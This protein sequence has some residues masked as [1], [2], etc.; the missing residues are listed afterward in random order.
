[1]TSE[2]TGQEGQSRIAPAAAARMRREI[3]DAGGREVFFAGSLNAQGL[4]EDV[5]VCAR[6]NED[7]VLALFDKLVLR[8]VVIHN[9]PTGDLG[10][11]EADMDVAAV[12][13]HN[14]HGVF[15]VDNAISRVYVVVEPFLE[16][17]TH[18][19]DPDEMARAFRPDG[20]MA[21]VLPQY[22]VRPQQRAMLESVARAFN[23]DGI[24]V[25][26]APTGVGKTFAYLIPAVQ[27]A[28]E[29][30][31]RVV[32][33]TRTINLQEQI[34]LKDIPQLKRCLGL[35]FKAVLVKGR[36]NYLCQR[37][38]AR[39]FSEM[40]LFEDDETQANLKSLDEW[41]KKTEDGSRSDLPF[42][43]TRDL[44]EKV[45]S[46]GDTCVGSRCPSAKTCFVT[47][48]RRE[49]ARADLIV[50]NHHMLFS[51]I[52]VKKDMGDFS[53][54]AVL[55]A[56]KRVLFDEAHSIEDS[57]T[58]YFGVQATRIGAMV[59]LGRFQ[60]KER[61]HERGLLPVVKMRLVKESN[62]VSSVECDQILDLIDNELLPSLAAVREAL[63][64]AFG[65]LR[66]LTAEKCGQI[67]R[68]IKW[69]LTERELMDPALRETHEVYVMP[70]VHEILTCVKHCADLGA[71]LRKIPPPPEELESPFLAEGLELQAYRTRLE[72]LAG[73]LS[74]CTSEELAPNTVR[75]VEIDS[76]KDQVLRM[77]RC[78]LDVGACLAEWV[79][80][81]LKTIVLT[82]ATLSVQQ[83]FDYLFNRIGLDRV[84]AERVRT[85]ILDTPF[86]FEMQARLCVVED[87]PSPNEPAFLE[88]TVA[89][90]RRILAVTRGRA[91]VL[92]TSFYALDFCYRRLDAELRRRGIVPLKQGQATRT[93][94][95]DQFRGDVSSVLFGTDSFWEGID[96][97]GEALQ[98]V[99]L[100][101]LP[102]RV[103]TEP[104]QQARAEAV[105]A[106][107][108]NSFMRYTVPQAV[109]K[110]R[111][112]FGRLIRRKTDRGAIVV[113]DQRIVTKRYGRVFLESLPRVQ[114]VRGSREAVY[115]A[116]S[117]FYVRKDG[118][119][120]DT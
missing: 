32:V 30:R 65:A 89:C 97:A 28:L 102:F 50:A 55:P 119:N 80:D 25:V 68:D 75:W 7:S 60:R 5:R 120:D 91:L 100:P 11:S 86:D 24:S 93:Q 35:D 99:I 22:E 90:L 62:L 42:M 52:A 118:K 63:S 82:S 66:S 2:G 81:N 37:K 36:S 98:C 107:G 17:D 74:E 69:R 29:N 40:T 95:L 46:E 83:R 18:K 92:F 14:G 116:L 8:D 79:Y 57:A 111:Q 33:S 41:A 27:W 43:P 108:G 106:A 44:W 51:D 96:V 13:A 45:R 115:E 103:P 113:L 16:R 67:G 56:Y 19:L 105:D 114:T 94:I 71:R 104:I 61:I 88:E 21:R 117:A 64:A 9:H 101:K 110:F 38:L 49:I 4:V 85:A 58:E 109:I 39:V 12:C 73:V 87:V 48:A 47:R 77:V 3:D 23:H 6:G 72:S 84:D 76:A 20:P 54:L 31:E 26:E 10:P 112:G 1:M 78:P 70:A 34:V 15:I 53:S 59:L